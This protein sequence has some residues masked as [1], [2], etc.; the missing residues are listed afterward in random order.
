MKAHILADFLGYAH[1]ETLEHLRQRK[2]AELS[3]AQVLTLPST[4][5]SADIVLPTTDGREPFI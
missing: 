1:W 4:I 5:Q 2:N 3:P